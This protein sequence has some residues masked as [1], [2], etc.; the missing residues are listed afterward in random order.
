MFTPM[1]RVRL[2]GEGWSHQP[3]ARAEG[4]AD[5]LWGLHKLEPGSTL[6]LETSS[7]HSIGLGRA[8]RAVALSD[9]YVV[10]DVRTVSPWRAMFF[11]DCRYVME[12]PLDVEPPPPGTRLEVSDV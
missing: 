2:S 7:I 8:F 12:L 1:K 6:L 10:M 5:R 4:F 11:R 9:E 3:V